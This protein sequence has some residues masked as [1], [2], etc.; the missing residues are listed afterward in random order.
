MSE[1][2]ITLDTGS[3]L[4]N[5]AMVIDARVVD[6]HIVVLAKA[7]GAQPWVTWR[8]GR[9]GDCFWGHYFH[10]LVSAAMDFRDRCEEL[11]NRYDYKNQTKVAAQ[12]EDQAAEDQAEAQSQTGR[13]A[14]GNITA[15][16]V[17][18]D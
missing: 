8:V 18:W 6:Q 15:E 3:V 13:G 14:G 9:H 16:D 10:D 5:H 12:A 11:Q 2:S 7:E 1:K 17:Y 4:P